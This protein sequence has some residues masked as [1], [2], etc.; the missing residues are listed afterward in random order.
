MMLSKE[1]C[2]R[3]MNELSHELRWN[4]VDEWRW[5]KGFLFCLHTEYVGQVMIVSGPP[6]WCLYQLEHAVSEVE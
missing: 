2:I 6:C 4:H 5:A 3:C 1:I